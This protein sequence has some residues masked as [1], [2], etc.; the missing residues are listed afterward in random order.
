MGTLKKVCGFWEKIRRGILSVNK[1]KCLVNV[2]KDGQGMSED[3]VP[4]KDEKQE[5]EEEE[6]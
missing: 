1:R 4:T 5:K 3:E 2:A 6:C